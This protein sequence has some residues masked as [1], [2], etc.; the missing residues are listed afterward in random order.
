MFYR[1]NRKRHLRISRSEDP[2]TRRQHRALANYHEREKARLIQEAK[3]R[4]WK[5][6]CEK[7]ENR[8]DARNFYQTFETFKTAQLKPIFNICPLVWNGNQVTN[9]QIKAIMCADYLQTVLQPP[10]NQDFRQDT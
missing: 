6:F 3:T 2:E 9:P 8:S 1:R 10:N 5:R 4:D 7:L